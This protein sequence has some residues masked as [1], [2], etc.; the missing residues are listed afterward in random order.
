V[1]HIESVDLRATTPALL[2][3]ARAHHVGLVSMRAEPVTL[4]D[5]VTSLAGRQL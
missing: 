4:T 2:G 5:V 1:L 3:W